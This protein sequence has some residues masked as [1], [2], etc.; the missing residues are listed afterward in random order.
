MNFGEAFGVSAFRSAQ[1]TT[2]T[3]SPDIGS[4]DLA[5]RAP[6]ARLSHDELAFLASDR[7]HSA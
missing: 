1:R 4:G 3:T 5:S 6:A 7:V 2:N